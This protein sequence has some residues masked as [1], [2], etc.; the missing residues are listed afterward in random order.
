VGVAA[1][2]AVTAVLLATRTRPA[3]AVV[4]GLVTA[5]AVG[6]LVASVEKEINR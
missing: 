4:A 3:R 1:G 6:A 2:L 5:V